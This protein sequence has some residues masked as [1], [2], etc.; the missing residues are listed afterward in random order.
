MCSETQVIYYVGGKKSQASPGAATWMFLLRFCAR[1][2][3]FIL[4]NTWDGNF[5]REGYYTQVKFATLVGTANANKSTFILK[6]H[7]L[8]RIRSMNF[9]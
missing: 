9:R 3:D 5:S 6:G 2:D 7:L 1:S 4:L 8:S